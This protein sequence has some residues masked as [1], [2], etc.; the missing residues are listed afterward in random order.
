METGT[1]I[2]PASAG[3]PQPTADLIERF[4]AIMAD[5]IACVTLEAL[6]AAGVPWALRVLLA[7]LV[8]R[9]VARWSDDFSSLVA[10]ARSGR[11]VERSA[12]FGD[13]LAT[14]SPYP[15]RRCASASASQRN[16]AATGRADRAATE[17]D[18]EQFLEVAEPSS[19]R[20]FRRRHRGIRSRARVGVRIVG[21][22]RGGFIAPPLSRGDPWHQGPPASRDARSCQFRGE[23]RAFNHVHFV[24]IS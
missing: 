11:L 22:A 19:E 16:R 9:R 12:C 23:A 5:L 21:I 7:P 1:N 15:G 6:R 24:T 17:R 20:G 2:A 4:N 13:D 14:E 18:A 10:E 3:P 8:R